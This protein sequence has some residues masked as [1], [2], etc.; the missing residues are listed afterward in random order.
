VLGQGLEVG[1]LGDLVERARELLGQA[2]QPVHRRGQAGIGRGRG[3]R[4]LGLGARSRTRPRAARRGLGPFPG[5]R[6]RG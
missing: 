3:T 2:H 6:L 4:R 1:G 5:G